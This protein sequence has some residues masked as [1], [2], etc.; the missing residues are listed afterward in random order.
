MQPPVRPIPGALSPPGSDP[1]RRFI[2][3]AIVALATLFACGSCPASAGQPRVAST[4]LCA[5]QLLLALAPPD[6][7]AGVSAFAKD[8]AVSFMWRRAKAFPSIGSGAERLLQL[9]ADLVLTGSYD[10]PYTREILR[11]RSV[12]FM[13]LAPWRT[14]ADGR[15]QIRQVAGVL[16]RPGAGEDVIARIDAAIGDLAS[17]RKRRAAESTVI[18]L[19]RRGYVLRAGIV[20][21][22]LRTAGLTDIGSSLETGVSGVASLERIVSL[23]P[24]YLVVSSLAER[25]EDQGQAKLAHPALRALYPQS[26]RIVLAD[27]LSNCAGLATVALARQLEQQ[28]LEKVVTR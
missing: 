11:R 12:R 3:L 27:R 24:D 22:L 7:I 4:N 6:Q 20:N 10:R 17:L 18:V 14:V 26:R 16:E 19:Y 25:P 28:I 23:R 15:S 21:E 9:D 1:A 2:A 13:V 5:D 8:P